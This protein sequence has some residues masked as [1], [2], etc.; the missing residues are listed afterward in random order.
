M[1]WPSRMRISCSTR[2]IT[3]KTNATMCQ[4]RPSED[5]VIDARV[6]LAG[7]VPGE[8]VCASAGRTERRQLGGRPAADHLVGEQPAGGGAEGDAPHAVATRR[9]H[10]RGPRGADERQPVRGARP[11]ADPLVLAGVEVGPLEE[12][13]RGGRDGLDPTLVETRL[14]G[15]ELHHPGD[16]KA[17]AER[18]AGDAL[19]RQVHGTVRDAVDRDREAVAATGLD[20]GPHAEPAGQLAHPRTGG[21]DGGVELLDA[22]GGHDADAAAGVDDVED[23]RA[24]ARGELATAS[25]DRVGEGVHV[26]ARVDEALAAQTDCRADLVRQHRLDGSR[27]VAGEHV[28]LDVLTGGVDVLDLVDALGGGLLRTLVPAPGVAVTDV[29]IAE[30][31]DAAADLRGDLVIGAGVAD[32]TDAVELIELAGVAGAAGVILRRGAARARGV[33]AAAKRYGVALLE[34]EDSA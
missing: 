24:R 19:G 34:L 31:G 15:A 28:E 22:T 13:P 14:G 2:A 29:V 9:I 17:V 4:V 21:Q 8:P 16:A 33:R 18:R 25:D 12:R 27:L 1:F 5:R 7:L 3:A 11:R 20:H 32:A 26:G 23:L 30:P 10:A 6:R